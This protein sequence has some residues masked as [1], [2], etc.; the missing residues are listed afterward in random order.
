[1]IKQNCNIF[2]FVGIN[3]YVFIF[4]TVSN[5][6][7]LNS[8]SAQWKSTVGAMLTQMYAKEC[9]KPFTAIKEICDT[10]SASYPENWWCVSYKWTS[11]DWALRVKKGIGE[12]AEWNNIGYSFK[13]DFLVYTVPIAHLKEIGGKCSAEKERKANE[14]VEIVEGM[15]SQKEKRVNFESIADEVVSRLDNEGLNWVHINVSHRY[16]LETSC[17]EA[18]SRVY[19]SLSLSRT[20]MTPRISIFLTA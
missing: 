1:M 9:K 4:C 12:S 10:L 5:L 18:I 13:Y 20:G 15:F 3:F 16:I 11:Y 2:L 8:I 14:I 17:S 7:T 19:S 6:L